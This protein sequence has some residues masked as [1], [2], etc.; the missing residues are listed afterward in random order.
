MNRFTAGG[1][2]LRQISVKREVVSWKEVDVG[3]GGV[4]LL[5]IRVKSSWEAMVSRV[6][7]VQSGKERGY[8]LIDGE[9]ECKVCRNFKIRSLTF[10]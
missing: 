10:M 6:N 8:G 1:P 4:E 9:G 7:W 5:L 2:T 3:V